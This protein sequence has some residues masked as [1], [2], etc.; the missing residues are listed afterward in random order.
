MARVEDEVRLGVELLQEV[1]G[2]REEVGHLEDHV[3]RVVVVLGLGLQPHARPHQPTVLVHVDL[4]L[5]Q[6]KSIMHSVWFIN[7]HGNCRNF[8]INELGKII[9]L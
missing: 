6:L 9:D 3:L 4:A 2:R 5:Q 1:E 7:F 8:D